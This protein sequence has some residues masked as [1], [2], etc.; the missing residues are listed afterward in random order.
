[1]TKA[2]TVLVASGR[3]PTPASFSPNGP[4]LAPETE[5]PKGRA[6]L[7]AST[8][9]SGRAS[10]HVA[11]PLWGSS[12]RRPAPQGQDGRQQHPRPHCASSATPADR[13][14]FPSLQR[15]GPLSGQA[16]VMEQRKVF[17]QREERPMGRNLKTHSSG[18]LSG[19]VVPLLFAV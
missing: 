9:S 12:L 2:R 4:L 16:W 17:P 11:V 6:G 5:K 14:L 8:T 1:M 10:L 13:A 19:F 3:S 7:R 15:G 18:T